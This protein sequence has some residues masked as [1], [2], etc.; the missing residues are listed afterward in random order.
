MPE[1]PC[2]EGLTSACFAAYPVWA[3]QAFAYKLLHILL[4][5][6]LTKMLPR[7][8]NLPMIPPG[9]V[10]TP[11]GVLP[12]GTIVPPGTVF[13]PGWSPGDPAPPGVV[14]PPGTV[15]PPGWSPGDPAPPGV[16]LPPAVSPVPPGSGALPPLYVQPWEPGPIK[17]SPRTSELK[18]GANTRNPTAD[19]NVTWSRSSGSSNYLLVNEYPKIRD[20]GYC[21]IVSDLYVDRFDTTV[22]AIPS[23]ATITSVEI[24]IRGRAALNQSRDIGALLVVALTEFFSTDQTW[25]SSGWT[26]KVFT[27]ENDPDGNV[28]WTPARA[29]DIG[30]FGYRSGA[31]TG[32]AAYVS[33]VYLKV[34]YTV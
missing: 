13:P 32:D 27:W 15:F 4:P 10:W 22:F 26:E 8:L 31:Y 14:I 11:G 9:V 29:N 24:Y 20:G 21:Y 28:P 17:T 6:Q 1:H 5:K 3:R 18:A 25:V 34:N 30:G 2:A 23:G 16:Q 12:P 19:S 7:G 33:R